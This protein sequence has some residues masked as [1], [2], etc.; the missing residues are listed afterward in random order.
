MPSGFSN[1]PVS[2]ATVFN[3]GSVDL[4]FKATGSTFVLAPGAH[5]TELL[6][7]PELYNVNYVDPQGNITTVATINYPSSRSISVMMG[8]QVEGAMFTVHIGMGG[9]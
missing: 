6:T 2:G 7:N 9:N 5:P 1:A 3:T 8:N 4:V